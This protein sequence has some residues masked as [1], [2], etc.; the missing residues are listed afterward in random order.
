MAGTAAIRNTAFS[1]VIVSNER[2]DGA[3]PRM[4]KPMLSSKIPIENLMGVDGSFFRCANCIQS[5]E[6]GEAKIKINM[7]LTDWNNE[8][9]TMLPN[10]FL[11]TFSFA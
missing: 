5:T 2:N 6:N 1:S 4:R 7:G 9:G 8:A 3:T 11:S 10:M